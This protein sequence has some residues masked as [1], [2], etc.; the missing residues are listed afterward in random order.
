MKSPYEVLGVSPDATDDEIKKAYRTL[1]RKYHPDSNVNSAH[2]EVAEEKFKEVQQAYNQIMKEKQQGYSGDY[3]R[4]PTQDSSQGPYGPY[5][6]GGFGGF[7]GGGY[8][9]GGY[10]PGGFGGFGGQSYGGQQRAYES[11]SPEMRAAVNYIN[12][13]HFAEAINCLNNIPTDHRNARW[14]YCSAVANQG[15]GNNVQAMEFARRAVD[16]EPSNTEYRN[17]LTNLENG[18]NWYRNM[19][20]SYDNPCGANSSL[21]CLLVLLFCCMCGG[22][23]YCCYPCYI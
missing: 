16:M 17:F 3:Q 8:G 14:Y 1:S 19:G 18:G 12:N 23:G 2:P 21:I 6:P 13:R 9:Q 15:A 22:G 4:G 11:D 7:G 20:S 5:G 10:G